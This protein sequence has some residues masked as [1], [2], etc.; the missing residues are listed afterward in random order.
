MSNNK[1][2]SIKAVK[3]IKE[4]YGDEFYKEIGR[5]GGSKSRGGG[6][7]STSSKLAKLYGQLGGLSR[8]NTDIETIEVVRAEIRRL[9]S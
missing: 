3:T 5:T 2:G 1:E 4:K 9:K 6:F 7:A 8:R